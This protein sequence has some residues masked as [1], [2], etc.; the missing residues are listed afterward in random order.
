MKLRKPK[1]IISRPSAGRI[2][3]LERTARPGAVA[4]P[5]AWDSYASREA[6]TAAEHDRAV[7]GHSEEVLCAMA[8]DLGSR[9]AYDRRDHEHRWIMARGAAVLRK[10]TGMRGAIR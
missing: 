3:P 2:S 10:L 5:P 8:K 9:R 6:K 1:V 7:E 4:S